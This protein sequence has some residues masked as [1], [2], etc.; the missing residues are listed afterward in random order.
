MHGLKVEMKKIDPEEIKKAVDALKKGGVIAYPT[1]AVYG[2]GCDPFNVD[3][4]GQ[5]L[6]IKHR[7]MDKGFILVASNWKQV[8]PLVEHIAPPL[9][10]QVLQNWP[11]PISWVFP[12]KSS[13]PAWITGKHKTIAL[14]VSAHPAIQ[15]LCLSFGGPIISTSANIEGQPPARNY[16]TVKMTFGK[17][18]SMIVKGEVGQSAKPSEIRDAITGE[19]IRKG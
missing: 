8:E 3:A 10:A 18:I 13:I 19:I 1:E 11:G 2:L 15:A 9:L 7:H 5:L 12:A 16:R 4:V 6:H 14:R 17:L